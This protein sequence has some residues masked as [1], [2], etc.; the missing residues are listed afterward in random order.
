MKVPILLGLLCFFIY[1]AN[2]RQI[3][4]G[5]TFPARYVP[6]ILWRDGT[7]D[8]NNNAHLIAYG[9]SMV[10]NQNRPPEYNSKIT[11]FEPRA[12]WLVRTHQHQLA[13]FYP[14]VT[15]LLVSP[16]YIPV[17]MWLNMQGWEQP[18]LD[19]VAELMEKIAAS[20]IAS[21]TSVLMYLVLRRSGNHWPLPL[22]IAFAFGTNTW[23]I[24]S[25][26]LWQHGT[27]ELLIAL[28][29]LLS[30]TSTSARSIVLLGVV[31]IAM[32]A[33]R[34]P[35][36]FI[37]GAFALYTIWNC[38]RNA[39]WLFV[40][41]VV[42]LAALLYY[43]LNF[44]GNIFG[45]YVLINPS[46][47]FFQSDWSGVLGLLV[48]PTRGL[49]VF[50][51]FLA[52]VPVGLIQRLRAPSTKILAA[53]LSLAVVA[54]ILVYS[55]LDWRAGVSW[56]PRWLTDILPVLVW[57]LAPATLVLRPMVR[58]LLVLFIVASIGVQAIG[59]FW[60]TQTS[61]EI[62]F[63]GNPTSMR[64]AW[65]FNNIPFITELQHS[66]ASGELLYS[67]RGSLD[68][69][70]D[71]AL[72]NASSVPK[73]ESGAVLEGW[74]LIGGRT[75]AQ[76]F[77][78]VDGVIVGSTK[79]FF[80]RVDVS[81]AMK[82]NAHSGW[83]VS[84]NTLGVLTG[85]RI[86]QVAVRM[87]P[88]SPIRIVREQRVIVSAPTPF[89][90]AA[91]TALKPVTPL[92]LDAM[93]ALATKR[94]IERQSENG[95][96]LTAHTSKLSYES[97]LQEMN[98]FMTSMLVDLLSSTSHQ[99]NLN[100]VLARAKS[101]LTAQIESNGLV[102]Y[103]GVPDSPIIGTLGCAITPDAD[104]T[105]LVW[106]IVGPNSNDPRQQLMLKVLTD[107]RDI[108]GLYRTWLAPQSQYQCIDPGLD[109][110]PTDITIQMHVYL[111]LREFDPPAAQ[112]LCRAL[113]RS[114]WDEDIWVY[115]S[116]SPLVPYLRSAE[117]RRHGCPI[118]LPADR[119]VLPAV[120]QE[121]WSEAMYLLVEKMTSPQDTNLQQAIRSVL[122]RIGNDDFAQL[123]RSPPM[124][125]H[126][127]RSAS[128]RRYYWSEDFGYAIWLLLYDAAKMETR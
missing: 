53:L 37:A 49:F 7:L 116:K 16:L 82:T 98:T 77:V 2:L 78:L 17:V 35:D 71:V 9:H 94:L 5:D 54:Q 33:N 51:P 58:G 47:I 50:S 67:A 61:D 96:W 68:R 66:P 104:D 127:D 65:D 64:T 32:V 80:S 44:I 22:T 74:A 21:I 84:I 24:S 31:C 91:T 102:R 38:W 95:Y 125:Y 10:P 123:R 70:G 34:P 109:P 41:A 69:V 46:N 57:M 93:A 73:L 85:E 60:Y 106:R 110:N 13:S 103:H 48:S 20:V 43:N 112:N 111:M 90:A 97:P 29:L 117:L 100:V 76:L 107:Y 72:A 83:R 52:F 118:P 40:G 126:N 124:L 86:L 79:D 105:A 121:I 120:D 89:I 119:L 63:A 39:V 12:Y 4:A 27:G 101:H 87:D 92:A 81:E 56:G 55:Q 26:A 42:P 113:Q 18:R 75:P 36:A 122:V 6:F 23:M 114:F 1:N 45:G 62:I 28:A 99:R 25:Q 11:Y 15:P 8:L 108:R 19:W 115:Y 59:A 3:G 14:I 88:R 30:I 128:V